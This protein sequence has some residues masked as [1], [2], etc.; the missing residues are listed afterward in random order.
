MGRMSSPCSSPI[1][2][3]EGNS[4]CRI[5]ALLACAWIELHSPWVVAQETNAPRPTLTQMRQ[6]LALPRQ[7]AGRQYPVKVQGV[8]TYSDPSWGLLFVQDSTAGVFADGLSPPLPAQPGDL[9]SIEGVTG[10]GI[11]SPIISS[12]AVR[13]L[14]Q[15]NL[16]APRVID[17]A[18]LNAGGSDSQWVEVTGV[19]QVEEIVANRLRLEIA[20]GLNRCQVW[21]LR[22]EAYRDLKLTDSHVKLRGV[23]GGAVRWA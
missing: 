2:G 10:S 1:S 20:S 15:T 21:V 6:V 13:L 12:G 3:R 23:G 9:L 17:I 18:E 22:A 8:V 16:P 19:V 7:E 11:F 5:I 14:Q 4:C